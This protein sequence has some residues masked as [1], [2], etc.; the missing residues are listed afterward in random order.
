MNPV[1]A[2]NHPLVMTGKAEV[3]GLGNEELFIRAAVRI[4]TGS[5]HAAGHRRMDGLVFK[6]RLI[7]AVEAEIGHRRNEEFRVFRDMRVMTCKAL[8]L[9]NRGVF[10]VMGKRCLIVAGKAEIGAGR[11]EKFPRF[12]LRF[13]RLRV[14]G[15]TTTGLDDRMNCLPFEL[16][17]MAL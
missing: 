10:D 14:A 12:C 3:R 13:V 8:P 4:V 11:K 7:M 15:D 6:L 5:A 17:L 9:G 2:R 1:L 16:D